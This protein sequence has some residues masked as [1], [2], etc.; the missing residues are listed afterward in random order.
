[1]RNLNLDQVLSLTRV[2]QLGSFSAA[3]K[4]LN[5]TQPAISLQVRDL[6][7]RMGVRLVE[8]LGRRAFATPAGQELLQRGQRLLRDAE[9]AIAAMQRHRE[10]RLG[11]VRLSAN[12]IFCSYLLPRAIQAFRRKRPDA[13]VRVS[14][15]S[16]ATA[17][18]EVLDNRYDLAV[19]TLPI[20]DKKL[21]VTPLLC[22]PLVAILPPSD[23]AAAAAIAAPELARRALILDL[24]TSRYSRLVRAWFEA[25]GVEPKPVMETSAYESVKQLVQAGL[26][27]SILP[28]VAVE[29]EPRRDLAI[30]PL[31]P[32][33]TWDLAVIQRRDR[34]LEPAAADMRDAL[35]AL[36]KR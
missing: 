30:R 22:E 2:V 9:E 36:R 14:I 13:E 6:E 8:R 3:A 17:V 1:M 28:R 31:R 29:S 15:S 21:T 24:P 20:S 26:A 27:A 4:A 7:E 33:L 19:I 12:D 32:A 34:K 10:G 18:D 5:L 11:R 16:T 23:P 35:M 25:S